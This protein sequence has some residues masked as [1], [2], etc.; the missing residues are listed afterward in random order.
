AKAVETAIKLARKWAYD[1]KG[2]ASDKAKNITVENNFHGRTVNIITFSTDPEARRNFG[3][4]NPG[5]V[6]IPYNHLDA[7]KKTLEDPDIA[8]FLVEPIQ[9][10]AGVFV[11]FE[12]YLMQAYTACKAANVLFIADEIQTGLARTGRMLAC[13]HE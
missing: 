13:D 3:P 7:L 12:G 2:I 9:G 8:A 5:H 4:F 1:A 10:E 6:T 11:P